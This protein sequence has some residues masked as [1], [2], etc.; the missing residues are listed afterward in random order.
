[1]S[2]AMSATRSRKHCLCHKC[3]SCGI[4]LPQGYFMYAPVFDSYQ[5]LCLPCAKELITDPM[6]N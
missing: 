3:A 4:C 5:Y 6:T 1:M 2:N